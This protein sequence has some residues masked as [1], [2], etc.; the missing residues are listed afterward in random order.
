MDPMEAR[1]FSLAFQRFLSNSMLLLSERSKNKCVQVK[2]YSHPKKLCVI[3]VTLQE[4]N[5]I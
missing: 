5:S 2:K 1:L 3:L 4:I